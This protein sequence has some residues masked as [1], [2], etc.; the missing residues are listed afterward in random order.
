M[1]RSPLETPEEEKGFEEYIS[2]LNT[3]TDQSICPNCHVLGKRGA[4]CGNV[5]INRKNKKKPSAQEKMC[6]V[7]CF[8]GDEMKS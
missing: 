2:A 3:Q 5:V 4:Y 8:E 6:F 1:Y 7:C